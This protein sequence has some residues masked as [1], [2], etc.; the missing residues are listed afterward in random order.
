M[1]FMY[2]DFE[3]DKNREFEFEADPE[4]GEAVILEKIENHQNREKLNFRF[5]N[6][7]QK[8]RLE[9]LRKRFLK[10]KNLKQQNQFSFSDA[11]EKSHDQE[12]KPGESPKP[13]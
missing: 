12:K 7:N 5:R 3:Y 4:S 6:D 10:E 9:I 2:D 13:D 11:V 8:N 1:R